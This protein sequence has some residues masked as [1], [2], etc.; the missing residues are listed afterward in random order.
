MPQLK[1]SIAKR[2]GQRYPMILTVP[3]FRQASNRRREVV[4][5]AKSST[6]PEIPGPGTC[7]PSS[8]KTLL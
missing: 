2:F 4:R 5:I 7:P 6:H 8:H 1:E 3:Q